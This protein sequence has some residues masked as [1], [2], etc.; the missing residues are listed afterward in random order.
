MGGINGT[1]IDSV[2]FMI[3][4]TLL[5]SNDLDSWWAGDCL[6]PWSSLQTQIYV[7]SSLPATVSAVCFEGRMVVGLGGEL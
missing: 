4:G 5:F 1:D 7:E 6:T 2:V 3:D